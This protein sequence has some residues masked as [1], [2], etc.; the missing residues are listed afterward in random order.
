MELSEKLKYMFFNPGENT[1][2]NNPAQEE[3][4]FSL[5]TIRPCFRN[6]Q[7]EIQRKRKKKNGKKPRPYPKTEK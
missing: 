5:N 2:F 6:R 3:L 4:F 7:R 1:K